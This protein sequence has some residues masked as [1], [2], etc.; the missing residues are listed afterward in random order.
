MKKSLITVLIILILVGVGYFIF[1][2]LDFVKKVDK[3][4]QDV[5]VEKV[6]I[7]S[8]RVIDGYVKSI[9]AIKDYEVKTLNAE[10]LSVAGMSVDISARIKDGNIYKIYEDTIGNYQTGHVEYYINDNKLIYV[11]EKDSKDELGESSETKYY[12]NNDVLI[13]SEILKESQGIQK[14][15]TQNLIDKY[16]DYLE[17]FSKSIEQKVQDTATAERWFEPVILNFKNNIKVTLKETGPTVINEYY[18]KEEVSAIAKNSTYAKR[19]PSGLYLKLSDGSWKLMTDNYEEAYSKYRKHTLEYFFKDFG[20]YS[21]EVGYYEGGV[22][23]LINYFTGKETKLVGRPYFSQNG[24]YILSVNSDLEAGYNPNGFELYENNKGTLELLG[25]YE[26]REWGP[27]SV[28]WIDDN[29]AIM[30]VNTMEV[31][32]GQMKDF[33]SYVELKIIK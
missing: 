33:E 10:Q 13:K 1:V 27:V 25:K 3:D 23:N 12:F 30:R 18:S 15:N 16:K 26:P 14:S 4:K 7:E 17:K 28:K 20:F 29:T 22:Y 11:Y 31:V 5:G 19:D 21:V 8:V 24:K 6:N 2:K 9:D 32:Q